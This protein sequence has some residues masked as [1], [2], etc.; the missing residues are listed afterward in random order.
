MYD[1]TL[2][3]LTKKYA[4]LP[5]QR[6]RNDPAPVGTRLLGKLAVALHRPGAVCF[7]YDEG[8]VRRHSAL[9]EPV[10]DALFG[11]GRCTR[12][13]VKRTERD[14]SGFVMGGVRV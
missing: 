11:Q 4:W 13:T 9:P 2:A 10:V 3:L 6:R 7:S 14:C 12:S 5:A 8:H 1:S